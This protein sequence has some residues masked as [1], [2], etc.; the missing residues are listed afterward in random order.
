MFFIHWQFTQNEL[1]SKFQKKILGQRLLEVIILYSLCE[2]FK[3][4]F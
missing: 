3:E 4:D 2:L 1:H